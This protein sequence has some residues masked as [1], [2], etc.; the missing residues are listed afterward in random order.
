MTIVVDNSGAA[1]ES[2]ITR[3]PHEHS[4][5]C[6]FS[7]L[8]KIVATNGG[9]AQA[10]RI[11]VIGLD[12][13]KRRL[14][15]RW[16]ELR[17]R[18]DA[19]ARAAIERCLW[20]E[21]IYVSHDDNFIIAFGRLDV[22]AAQ[23][24]C[25]LIA[26]MI[27]NSL[28]GEHG[29]A[30]LSVTTAVTTLE[31]TVSFQDLPSLDSLIAAQATITPALPLLHT[32]KKLPAARIEAV[33][34]LEM[35]E[36]SAADP[37]VSEILWRPIW[38]ARSGII[39]IYRP[40]L[41]RVLVHTDEAKVI[42]DDIV[43]CGTIATALTQ[44]LLQSRCLLFV[45][46]VHF[47]TLASVVGRHRYT[48]E[49]ARLIK[50]EMKKFL[51]ICLTDVPDGVPSSRMVELTGAL[52]SHCRGLSARL[53]LE[54]T[55][56]SALKGSRFFAVGADLSGRTD[57][58]RRLFALIEQFRRAADRAAF[59]NFFLDGIRTMSMVAAAIAEGFC[60]L[61]GDVVGKPMN[62]VIGARNFTLDDI[63]RVPARGTG[64]QSIP[65]PTRAKA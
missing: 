27:E 40:E 54:T 53:P 39:P 52:R 32:P 41:A 44:C 47:V 38:D 56:F 33:P 65:P 10:G 5:D 18:V 46:P 3:S 21:D 25:L 58:E 64:V 62:R 6:F 28:F 17:D 29:E 13:I 1:S 61:S 35:V 60:Y 48:E 57:T 4:E 45:L 19:I 16:D 59:C 63:Y 9:A 20:P 34:Q 31:G 36:K 43:L 15:D 37:Y 12:D 2:E 55:D 30:G 42:A 11:N 50:P 23:T 14:G 7:R 26:K 51:L 22:E 49:L 8:E 24:K